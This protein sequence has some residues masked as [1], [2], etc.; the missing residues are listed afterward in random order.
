ME[1]PKKHLS[2]VVED[3]LR[4]ELENPCPGHSAS[5]VKIVINVGG[6]SPMHKPMH[7][8]GHKPRHRPEAKPERKP[9]KA[10]K[11]VVKKKR[12]PSRKRS[13]VPGEMETVLG[14]AYVG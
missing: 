12:S 6:P 7:H 8:P 13:R 14:S 2:E 4:H 10:R 9:A 3:A 5:G 1:V 11:R